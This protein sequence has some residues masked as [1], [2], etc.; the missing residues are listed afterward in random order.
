M[1]GPGSPA[2]A[3]ERRQRKQV[4]EVQTICLTGGVSHGSLLWNVG[5]WKER[6]SH[7]EEETVSAPGRLF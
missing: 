3:V 4:G 6:V 7:V 2:E 1:L 5:A